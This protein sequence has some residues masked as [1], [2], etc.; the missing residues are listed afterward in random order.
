M[1][2]LKLLGVLNELV[3]TDHSA[4]VTAEWYA[5]RLSGASRSCLHI[6]DLGCGTGNSLELFHKSNPD[7]QWVG[8][9]IGDSP[10]VQSRVRRDGK[11]VTYD[12]RRIPFAENTFDVIYCKQV[13]EHVRYPQNL[14]GE[15]Q[16]VLKPHGYFIGSTSHLEPYHSYSYWNYTPFGFSV[17]V[18]DAGLRL[19]EIRP[20][21]DAFSMLVT[22]VLGW[23]PVN[24]AISALGRLMK[25]RPQSINAV[26]L[27]FCGQFCFWALKP[28]C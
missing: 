24:L 17:L 15:V 2:Y 14:I 1:R 19:L 23:F 11:F 13:L 28:E 10:E 6:M 18:R 7:I 8:L 27:L 12:G 4:Q 25:A 9:D 3:P 16:R 5:D 22:H 21:I 20:S 26:K